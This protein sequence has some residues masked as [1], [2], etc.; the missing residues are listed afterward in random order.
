VHNIHVYVLFISFSLV[1][2]IENAFHNSLVERGRGRVMRGREGERAEESAPIS[3]NVGQ[4]VEVS[5]LKRIMYRTCNNA[6][7]TEIHMHAVRTHV[8]VS[9]FPPR[10]PH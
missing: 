4:L 1:L 8:N 10:P 2:E 7:A 9:R 6:T 3:L 5:G